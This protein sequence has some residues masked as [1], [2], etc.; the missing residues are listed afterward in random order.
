M[1]LYH[2]SVDCV[3]AP[4]IRTANRTLDYGMGFYTTTSFEQAETW[5]R[6]K[7][8]ELHVM[9]GF[10]NVYEFNEEIAEKLKQLIFTAP[11]ES[12]LDFVM[13]NRTINGFQHDNDIVYGPVANDRVYT[14][15]GLYEGGILGKQQL[16]AELKT[17][18]LVDQYL[19]HTERSLA[20]LTF[21]EA[22]EIT[23]C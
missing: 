23:I 15:F 10:V 13:N 2:G 7:M 5:V 6:R 3:I 8:K 20:C 17:Y 1:K 9:Q 19:F 18:K 12:W 11:D 16:I 21:L 4:E 14:A 22:K